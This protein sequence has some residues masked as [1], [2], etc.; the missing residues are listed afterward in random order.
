MG[1]KENIVRT[2]AA[3]AREQG[4]LE[5]STDNGKS[6]REKRGAVKVGCISPSAAACSFREEEAGIVYSRS[7][8]RK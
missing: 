3:L 1:K 8:H 4:E 6:G 7:S 5:R 2:Q